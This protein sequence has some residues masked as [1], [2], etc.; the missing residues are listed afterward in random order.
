M[1]VV[2]TGNE[3]TAMFPPELCCIL[4][5]LRWVRSLGE[6]PTDMSSSVPT[7]MAAATAICEKGGELILFNET[8]I[9]ISNMCSFVFSIGYSSFLLKKS[10]FRCCTE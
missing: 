8:P 1:L 4:R 6:K 9:R 7:P 2:D 10:N 5:R 3:L